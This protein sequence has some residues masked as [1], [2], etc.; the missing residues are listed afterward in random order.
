MLIRI[1]TN[2]GHGAGKPTSKLIE[3]RGDVLSFIMFNLGMNPKL[4]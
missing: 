1:D 4:K 3:E 2:A